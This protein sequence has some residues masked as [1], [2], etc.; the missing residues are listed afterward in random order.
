MILNE[1]NLSFAEA[2]NEA[3]HLAMDIDSCVICFGLGI[4][5]PKAIFG[6]TSFLKD[7][8]G[9]ERV[10]DTPTSENGMTGVAVGAALQGL[11]PVMVHQRADFF[12]LAMDQLVNSAAK[13]SYM[14]GGQ[15]KV[16]L[17][18]RLIQGRGW[19][20]GPTHSQTFHAWFTHVPGLKVVMPATGHDAKGLLLSSI[21]DDDPVIFIEHRWLHNSFSNV[22]EE[23]YR[24]PLGQARLVREGNDITI[25][26]LSYMLVEAIRAVNFLAFHDVD[27]ELIDPRTLSPFDW[28]AVFSSVRKTGHLLVIDTGVTTGSFAGEIV[29]RCAMECWGS[30][31]KAPFRIA[32][33]DMPEPTSFG[34][35]RDLHPRAE[36]V[37][38]AVNGLLDTNVDT[39]VLHDKSNFPHDVPGD[40]FKGP[41]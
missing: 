41:F 19:G 12:L 36:D 29:A 39:T 11:R 6:T 38:E 9:P 28:D 1:R 23:D 8:F 5:D 32:M 14:F 22:P 30:L 35:T 13:W 31:H 40:W 4:D 16:P 2:L 37:V 27:C 24:I 26:A 3:I 7:K 17:V 18:I 34:L 10:F 20:Q 15:Q 25:I 33:P 21:F